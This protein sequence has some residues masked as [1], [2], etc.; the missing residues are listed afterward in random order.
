M[1]KKSNTTKTTRKSGKRRTGKALLITILVIIIA[2]FLVALSP[3][4][5]PRATANR[6]TSTVE[7]IVGVDSVVNKGYKKLLAFLQD[8]TKNI[9]PASSATE[10]APRIEG[11]EIPAYVEG[12]E[13][14]RHT[15]YTLS[16]NEQH[17]VADW[18][19]YE[20]TA[21]E[22]DTQESSRSEDFRPDE[23]V[24]RSSQLDDYRG[25]GYSRGHLAPAQD[26]KWSANAMS[27]TF[28]L[29]NMVPQEQ[30]N[31]NGGIW[32]KAENATRDCA[33][34]TGTVYVVT[35]PVL[36]DGPFETIGAN[37][38]TVPKQCYKALLII[39]TDGTVQTIAMSIPQTAKKKESIS[40]Y[41][42]T[43]DEL[44]KLTGLDFFIELDDEIENAAESKFDIDFWPKSFR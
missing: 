42:M 26:F 39:D 34:I 11:L 16:W 2:A 21:T 8:F 12:H 6:V 33:R 14:V 32:L 5:L 28:Y 37:K 35:G 23:S 17:L 24:R 10:S 30:D 36:T 29:T 19:A 4:F 18:V 40:N 44:E 1:S 3:L 7:K 25:S 15:G 43:V 41:L 20:L 38:V 13:V 27:D 31:Y 9:R 22:L